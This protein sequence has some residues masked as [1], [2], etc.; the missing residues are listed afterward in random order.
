MAETGVD[1]GND[2]HHVGLVAVDLVLDL[3]GT[4]AVTGLLGLF[5]GAEQVVELPGVGLAQE[6]VELLDQARHGGLLVHG[7]VGQ[8]AEL[9][10]QG[11]DHPAGEVE[12]AALGGAE[13]LLDGD[14]LLLADEAVPA[15]Q[16]LGVLGGVGVVGRHVFAHDLRGVLGDVQAGLEAVLGTHAGN[17]LGADVG[18]LALHGFTQLGQC[19]DVVLV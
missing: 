19:L 9:G 13:V 16:G 5:Q 1:V 10:A 14:Q 17:V 7:L 6:G 4:G 18:P 12:V 2:R 3:G 15:A 8:R 11:G